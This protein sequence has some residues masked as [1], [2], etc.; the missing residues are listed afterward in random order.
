MTYQHSIH[1]LRIVL[2]SDKIFAKSLHSHILKLSVSVRYV[3]I[4]KQKKYSNS[5]NNYQ[6]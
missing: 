1:G 3:A 4:N 6:N 2:G 5:E